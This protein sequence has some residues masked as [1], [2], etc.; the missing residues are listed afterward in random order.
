VQQNRLKEQKRTGRNWKKEAG[1][2]MPQNIQI[3][4]TLAMAAKNERNRNI[5]DPKRFGS[6]KKEQSHKPIEVTTIVGHSDRLNLRNVDKT[7][8]T[9]SSGPPLA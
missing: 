3:Y 8:S 9:A 5:R 7:S 1:C 4:G 6:S 2:E